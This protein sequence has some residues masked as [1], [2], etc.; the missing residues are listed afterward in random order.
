MAEYKRK[1]LVLR[2]NNRAKT[3]AA[4]LFCGTGVIGQIVKQEMVGVSLTCLKNLCTYN[5]PTGYRV[6]WP[7]EVIPPAKP[8][9][10][11]ELK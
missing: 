4:G 8:I 7:A 6:L 1:S 3:V 9:G 2:E 11:R 5:E 10:K